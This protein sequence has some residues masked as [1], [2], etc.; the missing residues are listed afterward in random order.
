VGDNARF[1]NGIYEPLQNEVVIGDLRVQ[2]SIPKDQ[3]HTV[4]LDAPAWVHDFM[5]TEDYF[6]VFLGPLCW[7]NHMDDYVSKG[8]S[9]F[10]F[11]AD[12][13]TR[14]MLVN[15]TT[16]AVRWFHDK[17]TYQPN[18]YLN[19]YQMGNKVVLDGTVAEVIPVAGEV[20]VPDFFP[21]PMS[22]APNPF[23]PPFLWR[24]TFDL[25][26]G[27]V[28]HERIGEFIREF[29]RPN[30]RYMGNKH[31]YGDLSGSHQQKS[32][33]R[34][35]NC[36]IKQDFD[37]GQTEYQ[38]LSHT[39]DMSPG[40]PIFVPRDGAMS[41]DDGYLLA[42]WWDPARDKSE[43]VI[44]AAQDF[45]GEPL[46]RIQLDHRVP[47]GFHGNWISDAELGIY[48]PVIPHPAKVLCVG[49]N[50]QGHRKE[51]GRAETAHPAIFTRF[52]DSLIGQ[53]A[54]LVLPPNSTSLDYEGELAVVIGK[55]GFRVAEED[56]L[57]LVG[58]YSI[59]N[60]GTIRDWQHHTHQFTPGKNFPGTG[61]FG[62]ALFTPEEAGPLEEKRIETRVNGKVEQEAVLG[63]MI[64]S[65]AAVIAYVSGFTSL[66][67]GDVIAMG[68]PGGVGF[69]RN[70]PLFL[71]DG[72]CV[73]V[74]IAGLG[75]LSNVVASA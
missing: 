51:T 36:L 5:F 69:K 59:F 29:V 20:V 23:T 47:L 30:E 2:G 64:F 35:F 12:L 31:R 9:T 41:E 18:H 44:H 67:P 3:R 49:L 21:F 11:D 75:T 27:T 34:Q 42:V 32:D 38:Y 48:L 70:P 8:K 62:P 25:D 10:A 56:A 71:K 40:E 57:H 68:T 66:K 73:E 53:N 55:A 54:A 45:A 24:W 61:A 52:A 58:G 7:H 74:S 39:S 65:V 72:D 43:M 60:D 13:G 4:K 6:I 46:A 50:Y 14:I 63:D 22:N 17:T 33:F 28:A 15:R 26:K 37:T 1:L 16:G 19:A